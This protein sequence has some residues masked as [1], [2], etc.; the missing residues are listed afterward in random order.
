[1]AYHLFY[2]ILSLVLYVTG[3]SVIFWQSPLVIYSLGFLLPTS[4]ALLI[5]LY[6]YANFHHSSIS[7]YF[8][9]WRDAWLNFVIFPILQIL[10]IGS[11]TPLQHS[12]SSYGKVQLTIYSLRFKPNFI[13]FFTIRILGQI[14]QAHN[15]L[16]NL[17]FFS[18]FHVIELVNITTLGYFENL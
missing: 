18:P 17:R 14:S 13:V 6:I 16:L 9:I 10:L 15:H 12:K 2:K 1:M 7:S 5:W 3:D 11:K 8:I 4:F